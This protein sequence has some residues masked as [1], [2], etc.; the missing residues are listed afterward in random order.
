MLR[1]IFSV[2]FGCLVIS[3][4]AEESDFQDELFLSAPDQLATLTSEPNFLVGG[5]ISPI[6][7][8]P[9][10]RTTDLNVKGAQ[11]ISLT[12]IYIPPYIP[13][14]FPKHEK[15]QED[16]DK[17]FLGSILNKNYEGWQFL[18]HLRLECNPISMKVR[19]KESNGATF[20]FH[21]SESSTK[22]A[23]PVYA[24]SN[25]SGDEPSG[26][27][28][29]R[30][31]RISYEENGKKIIVH[32]PDGSV[33]FYEKYTLTKKGFWLYLLQKESLPNGKIVK[34]HYNEKFQPIYI[35][36]LDPQ[37][38]YV[39]ASLRISGS[40]A[41]A[42]CHFISSSGQIADYRYQTR[43]LKG[44]TKEKYKG[45]VRKEKFNIVCPP[46]LTSV[47]SPFYRFESLDYCDRFLLGNY[48]GKDDVFIPHHAG[49]GGDAHYRVH[50]LTL[51]VGENDKFE[52]VYELNYEPAIPGERAGQTT[53]KNSDG[54]FIVYLLSKDLLITSIQ[55]FDINGVLKKEK[56]YVWDEE[57]RLKA[58]ESK[59][60]QKRIIS[61]K[62][63]EHDRYGN[64]VTETFTGD[65]K[66]NGNLESYSIWREFSEDG[67][68]LLLKEVHENGKVISYT[69]L[70]NTNLVTAKLTQDFDNILIRE[71]LIYDESFNLVKKISD[72]GVTTSV[73]D[74]SGV[75][76]R[77]ITNYI[78]RQ[79]A[80]FLHMPEWIEQLYLE[81]GAEKL[82]SRKH[83]SYDLWGNVKEEE[84]YDALG[85]LAYTIYKEYNESGH[86]ISETNPLGLQA[87]YKYDSRG[88]LIFES[89]FSGR[90][91]KTIQYDANGRHRQEREICDNGSIY[92]T[93]SEYDYHDRL[94]KLTD[95]FEN[96]TQYSYDPVVG[97]IA[98]I[99]F[100]SIESSEGL[101][102]AVTTI[103]TYDSFGN[104]RTSMDANQG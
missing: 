21:V 12:R 62:S 37:E 84:Y 88:Q 23:S 9:V 17:K 85:N 18:P 43:S 61:V 98:K 53:V 72:N 102:L 26:Q 81:D 76:E 91:Q 64:P 8:H 52:T 82:L 93:F 14:S 27:Y 16:Y 95:P 55:H 40:P 22:L 80:P 5:L 83:L 57:N 25:A 32:T 35:E 13:S 48:Q 2:F 44:E 71:F 69:Y 94:T 101:P 41:D 79:Q 10:L 39:Y 49:F 50:K 30:N 31:T 4:F 92:E 103:S 90:L 56:N 19:L 75:T 51:P 20:D 11:Q 15:Y 70:P 104:I 74:V 6:S 67:K 58:I 47:S 33:R 34:Y 78:L 66:G 86:L 89:N 100:P 54:S 68:H 60:E 7:G 96:S 46:I 73:D 99:E 29:P 97:K 38:K 87:T 3:G 28:D 65:L 42:N 36:S 45:G 1:L 24:I 77:K 59:D 63:Y